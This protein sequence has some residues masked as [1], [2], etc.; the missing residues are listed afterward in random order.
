MR[1]QGIQRFLEKLEIERTTQTKGRP[2]SLVIPTQLDTQVRAV[3]CC[4]QYQPLRK[5]CFSVTYTR[6]RLR[7]YTS[8]LEAATAAE[9]LMVVFRTNALPSAMKPLICRFR[10]LFCQPAVL[11]ETAIRRLDQPQNPTAG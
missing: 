3:I 10:V 2:Y 8:T 1:W 7:E 11:R 9:V 5:A 6:F 4:E